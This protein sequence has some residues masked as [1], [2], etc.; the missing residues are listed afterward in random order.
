VAYSWQLV[1]PAVNRNLA[2]PPQFG[3]GQAAAAAADV[4]FDNTEMVD[5][6]Q[7]G[8]VPAMP[9]AVAIA[10]AGAGNSI[11]DASWSMAAILDNVHPATLD[12]AAAAFEAVVAEA[13]EALLYA[14]HVG[15]R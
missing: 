1:R 15:G 14:I 3:P 7:A 10:H 4:L 13:F 6:A 12:N 11:S 9:L 2:Q 8:P 5:A